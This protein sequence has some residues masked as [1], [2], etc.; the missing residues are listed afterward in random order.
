MSVL[1]S[2]TEKTLSYTHPDNHLPNETLYYVFSN[3]NIIFVLQMSC[4]VDLNASI[5]WISNNA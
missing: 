4:I 1:L 2:Y 5:H 3:Y